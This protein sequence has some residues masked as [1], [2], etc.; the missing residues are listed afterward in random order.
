MFLATRTLPS[1]KLLSV[2]QVDSATY[3]IGFDNGT[4]Y[5]YTYNPNSIVSFIS[6]VIAT[7]LQF[8]VANNEVITS[9]GK[10]I[11][12]YS[13]SSTALIHTANA[14]DSVLNLHILYNK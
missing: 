8:D 7:H 6:G 13:Y 1:A 4:I 10:N 3:L 5:K 2:A 11:S 12:E 14:Q 9:S